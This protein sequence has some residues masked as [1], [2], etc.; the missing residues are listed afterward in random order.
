M[1]FGHARYISLSVFV[2][3]K[4]PAL[5]NRMRTNCMLHVDHSPQS[6]DKIHHLKGSG[7][8]IYHLFY[9]ILYIPLVLTPE[10]L[11]ISQI[12]HVRVLY[13]QKLNDGR[14]NGI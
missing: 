13:V 9:Y 11:H 5:L 7:Y 1:N 2:R 4:S 12:I 10:P 14:L 6:K 8:Y 3:I